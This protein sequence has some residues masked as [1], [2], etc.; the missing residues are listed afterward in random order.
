[1]ATQATTRK[2]RRILVRGSAFHIGQNVIINCEYNGDYHG[3]V[4]A[5]HVR[6]TLCAGHLAEELTAPGVTIEVTRADG[7]DLFGKW[8]FEINGHD[9]DTRPR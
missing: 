6:L 1:M 9:A 5:T 7:V 3:I 4:T 2:T 8:R